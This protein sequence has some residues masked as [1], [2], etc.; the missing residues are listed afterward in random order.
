MKID[1]SLLL[2]AESERGVS[3][4]RALRNLVV[5]LGCKVLC[6]GVETEEQHQL[7]RNVGCHYGQGFLYYN[8]M[9]A[10]QFTDLMAG[11]Q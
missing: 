6:E 7:A 10:E 2:A 4:Y 1:R 3:A 11:N 5:D 8:P 9:D